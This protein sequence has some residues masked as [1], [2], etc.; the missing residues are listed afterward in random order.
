VISDRPLARSE[1]L[2]SEEVDSQLLLYDTES[3]MAHALDG[4][5]VGVWRACD[6]HTDV[7]TLARRCATSEDEVRATLGRLDELG[8][9][10][11]GGE[12]RRSALIKLTAAGVGLGA[13]IPTI[14]SIVVPTAAQAISAQPCTVEVVEKANLQ[15]DGTHWYFY[16]DT[17]DVASTA[18]DSAHYKF[19]SGP[20]SPPAGGGSVFFHNDNPNTNQ[21]WDIN[22]SRYG[23]TPLSSLTAL[24]FNTF[25][26]TGEGAGKAIFLNFDVDFGDGLVPPYQGRLLY[27]P[28]QNGTVLTNTWQEWDT[29]SAGALWGWSHYAATS[30]RWPDGDTTEW[31]TWADILAAF[32]NAKINATPGSSQLVFRAGEPYPSGFTGYL[33]KVTVGVGASCTIFD[34]EPSL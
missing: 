30:N 13:G 31:R 12:T 3:H 16:N 21:R 20:G 17:T 29:V 1:G 33:D 26:P 34:F 6:G 5:A 8:L 2:V 10:E 11:R 27:V 25:Q 19:V 4:G 22:T 32:P 15:V 23:G 18:E 24:S 28:T 14:A 9:L 7:Q